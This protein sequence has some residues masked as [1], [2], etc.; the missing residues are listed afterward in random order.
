[1]V[2]PLDIKAERRNPAH[3]LL[4][5]AFDE[6]DLYLVQTS[7]SVQLALMAHASGTTRAAED[8]SKSLTVGLWAES[9]TSKLEKKHASAWLVHSL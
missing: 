2:Q 9:E 6:T 7:L 8:F 4:V 5:S 1:L 3:S